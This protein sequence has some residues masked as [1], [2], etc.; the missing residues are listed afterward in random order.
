MTDLSNRDSGDLRLLSLFHYIAGGITALFALFPVVHLIIGIVAI[1]APEAMQS[2]GEPPPQWF[3]WVF[4][5]IASVIIL[6]GWTIAGLMIA[7]GRSMARGKRHMFC[8]VVAGLECLIMPFGTILG[9]FTIIVLM[10]D[11]VREAFMESRNAG[12]PK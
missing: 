5:T 6:A 4:V 11:S 10:R 2:E 3:G 12:N 7:A 8:L 9:V 1:V